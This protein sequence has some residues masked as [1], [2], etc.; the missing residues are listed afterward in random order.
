MIIYKSSFL[1][2]IFLLLFC[3]K[4]TYS[5]SF[6]DSNLPIVIITTDEGQ[7]IPDEPK[8]GAGMKIIYRGEGQRNYL[9]DESNPA[10]LN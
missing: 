4:S 6:T 7:A 5:Q 8:I 1:F 3:F 9:T 10:Y 2:S